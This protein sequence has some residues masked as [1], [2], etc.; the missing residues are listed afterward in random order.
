MGVLRLQDSNYWVTTFIDQEFN[1]AHE[2]DLQRNKIQPE[3]LPCLAD[4]IIE[5]EELQSHDRGTGRQH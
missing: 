5:A 4:A 2:T 3:F 1:R